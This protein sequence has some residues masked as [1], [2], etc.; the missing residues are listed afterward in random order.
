MT[1]RTA[2]LALL[3]PL[4]AGVLPL[5][6]E[7]KLLVTV[8]DRKAGTPVKDLKPEEF[9]VTIGK[10]P[11]QVL[12]AE[13]ETGPV[14]VVLML[15]TSLI[16]GQISS[17][18]PSLIGE[19]RE[20]EQMAIVAYHSA[21]DLIQEFTSSKDL[22]RRALGQVKFGN[23][24]RLL[25]ALYAVAADGFE[26]STYRRVILLLTTGVDGPSRVTREEVARICRRN[27]VSIF[28][29]Y[30]MNYGRSTLERLARVTAGA[31]FNARELSKRSTD[32]AATVFEVMRGRYVVTLA[33]NLP[34]GDK[35][36]LAI[37]RKGK[38]FASYLE[39]D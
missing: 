3:V 5:T 35:A 34:L 38:Y 11:R 9:R 31:A 19:L 32:P 2:G 25:D 29:V 21:A 37:Q 22:L 6:A 28:P 4:L 12:A 1:S 36:K 33:G 8:T 20:N 7:T 23:S 24:P 18:A 39:V 14:D 26:G 15:D 10:S 30:M 13:Y 17:L 27:A 16:G